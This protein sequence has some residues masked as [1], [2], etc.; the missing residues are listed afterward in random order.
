[1]IGRSVY[2]LDRMIYMKIDDRN[3]ITI[4]KDKVKLKRW[5]RKKLE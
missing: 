2:S 5:F 3:V 4:A 1:M